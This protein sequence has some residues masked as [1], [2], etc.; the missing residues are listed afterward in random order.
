M[1]TRQT[2]YRVRFAPSPT[3]ELHIG[4]ARTALYNYLIAKQSGGAFILRIED[5]DQARKVAG[6]VER[7]FEAIS[8]L[9][10]DIDEGPNEGGKYGPYVQ[11]ER[12]ERYRK[13]AYELVE[14]DAAYV[15][16][17]APA[18]LKEVRARQEAEKLP[19]RYDR[20][21]RALSQDEV[22]K[23]RSE[24]HSAVI[25][26]KVPATGKTSFTDRIRGRIEIENSELDDSV[27][28]KSDGFPTYHLAHVVDDHAMDINLVIRGEEWVPSTPKH[29][30]LYE[31]FGWEVP[32]FAHVPQL[33][34]KDRSKLSKRHGAVSVHEFR[35]QG[36]L[37]EALLNYLAL[38]GW[39]PGDERELFTLD[40]LVEEFS[41][42]RV[43]KSGAIYDEEKLLWMNGLYIRKISAEELTEKLTPALE[44][45]FGGETLK[46]VNLTKAVAS[47]QDRM[48]TLREA[49][50]LMEFFFRPPGALSKELLV[51][52]KLR[53]EQ[54]RSGLAFAHALLRGVG[55]RDLHAEKLKVHFLQEIRKAGKGNLEVL[56]PMRVAL[57]G[58]KA[59]PDVFDVAEALGRAE[60][61]SRIER[62]L[63]ALK[64]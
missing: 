12:L 11:S 14:K 56:W 16:F 58:R 20:H 25:R 8:W 43:M 54:V 37:P 30:L 29:L 34:A 19:P 7:I 32:E 49:G 18:R 17:C 57:T 55:E 45:Q 36:I 60:S 28:L 31:A 41:L 6:S 39:N 4:G 52:E 59:S 2:K 46:N 47:V 5:T 22:T 21:C 13:A 42:D 61:L 38:L 1:K 62:A 64:A 15:C 24:G 51:H 33:L 50:E 40:E 53:T 35:E 26:Q 27:L 63:H 3:G 44:R 10:L 23:L 48:R 9:G